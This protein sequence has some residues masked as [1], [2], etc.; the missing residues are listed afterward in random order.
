[1]S[2]HTAA[3]ER[4]TNQ[5]AIGA[6]EAEAKE[7]VVGLLELSNDSEV[8]NGQKGECTKLARELQALPAAMARREGFMA[9]AISLVN[10]IT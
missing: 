3:K 6:N 1:M 4:V 7:A 10:R 8:P 9:A 2:A 5:K